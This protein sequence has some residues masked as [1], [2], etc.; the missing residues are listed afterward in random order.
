M[1]PLHVSVTPMAG[2][3]NID[4]DLTLF[5]Q[6]GLFLVLMLLLNKMIFQPFLKSIDLR[7]Q[8]TDKAREDAAALRAR[9]ES[10]SEAH[11]EAV[12]AARAE[13]ASERQ[14]LRVAGLASKESRVGVAR[15]AA[16]NTL[17]NAQRA[18]GAQ[19]S[20]AREALLK[21]VDGLSE[22]IVAKVLGRGV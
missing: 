20:S 10:L 16:A 18:A 11:R 15:E 9:A 5:I 22:E 14:D 3:V 13:A 19:F 6:L 8:K 17:A 4:I 21:D 2:G 1:D 12:Q 7:E